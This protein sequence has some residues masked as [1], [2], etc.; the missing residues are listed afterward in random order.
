MEHTQQNRI[1]RAKITIEQPEPDHCHRHAACDKRHKIQDTIHR[2]ALYSVQS[3][4]YQQSQYD[5]SRYGDEGIVGGIDESCAQIAIRSKLGNKV[6]K[7]YKLNWP[8]SIPVDHT[9]IEHGKERNQRESHQTKQLRKQKEIS[10]KSLN[11]TPPPQI[12][13]P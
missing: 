4:R 5:T 11:Q 6:L 7:A 12:T 9:Q 13:F 2:F 10:P 3:K 1:N 8:Q